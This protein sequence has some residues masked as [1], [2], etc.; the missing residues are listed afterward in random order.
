[1]SIVK[2]DWKKCNGSATCVG[3]CPVNVYEMQNLSDY[4]NSPKSVPVREK[5]CILCLACVTSCPT[6]AIDV[7]EKAEAK[8]ALTP[9]KTAR[10]SKKV[11]ART[12]V[13]RKKIAKKKTKAKK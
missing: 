3:V 9:A 11:T 13:T 5:D 7:H 12:K 10:T 4:P 6:Q 1:M 2:V 8:P